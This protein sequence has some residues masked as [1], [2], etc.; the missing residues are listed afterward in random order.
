MLP[1]RL[2]DPDPLPEWWGDVDDFLNMGRSCV[3]YRT[4]STIFLRAEGLLGRL[5]S[6][7]GAWDTP[8]LIKILK[9]R[10]F[11]FSR[12]RRTHFGKR[13]WAWEA[14]LDHFKRYLP[15]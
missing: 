9:S 1:S 15:K 6:E 4:D 13:V 5:R 7:F 12:H 11:R 10:E 14:D 3:I 2:D 8:K